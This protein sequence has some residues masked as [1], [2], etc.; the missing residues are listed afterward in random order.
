MSCPKQ[1]PRS[2]RVCEDWRR[3]IRV[4]KSGCWIMER[5]RKRSLPIQGYGWIDQARS[6]WIGENWS[7]YEVYE[8]KMGTC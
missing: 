6:R 7:V 4:W 1:Q 8:A 2:R 3:G 5:S